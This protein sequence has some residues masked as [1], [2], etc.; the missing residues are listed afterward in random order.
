MRYVI[1]ILLPHP[2]RGVWVEIVRYDDNRQYLLC[3]TPY[4]VCELK[5]EQC[6]III[7][8]S[9]RRTPY[10]VCELKCG[11]VPDPERGGMSHPLRGAWVEI[12]CMSDRY[13]SDI[14]RTPYGV[15]ELKSCP[16]I[17]GRVVCGRTPYGVCVW[18][19]T[20][21]DM[22]F[23]YQHLFYFIHTPSLIDAIVATHAWRL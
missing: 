20:D 7:A 1:S 3:R 6:Q 19:K 18:N 12:S 10:G 9:S 13:L 21:A 15:R 14:R 4:G 5:S 22:I 17:G 11:R 8:E 23:S 2:L 16:C